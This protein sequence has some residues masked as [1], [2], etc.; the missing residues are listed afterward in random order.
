MYTV[1]TA[2]GQGL[3]ISNA[4]FQACQYLDLNIQ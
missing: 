1:A 3:S 2:L 4:Y